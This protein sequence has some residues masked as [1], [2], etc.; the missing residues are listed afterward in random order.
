MFVPAKQSPLKNGHEETAQDR[1]AML[2]LAIEDALAEKPTFTRVRKLPR[3]PGDAPDAEPKTETIE[4]KYIFSVSDLEITRPGERSYTYD[5]LTTL[6][7]LYPHKRIF[8]LVG[9]DKMEEIA[10]WYRFAELV[11][12]F[13]FLVYRRPGYP[14]PAFYMLCEQVGSV[15]AARLVSALLPDDPEKFPQWELSSSQIREALARG[16]VPEAQLSPS[17]LKYIQEHG[18]YQDTKQEETR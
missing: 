5:T 9:T 6:K 15:V 3:E 17:V 12:H 7:R 18:L 13:D 14:P 4:Q 8:F 2:N 10:Q 11:Q 16:E 1:L